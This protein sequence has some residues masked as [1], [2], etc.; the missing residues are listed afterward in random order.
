MKRGWIAILMIALSLL[1]AGIE[2]LYVTG[3]AGVYLDMLNEADGDMEQNQVPE[4]QSVVERL[5]YRYQKQSKIFD[6]F[7]YHSD[8]NSVGS[9]L[10]MLRRYAQV[11][12]TAEF[13]ATSAR[14]KRQILSFS[15]AKL[16]TLENIL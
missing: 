3:N 9:D 15:N 5:D 1:T 14:A 12:D 4:A 2:Y 8:V 16:P 10:A 6:I 7:M 11:G 13:L